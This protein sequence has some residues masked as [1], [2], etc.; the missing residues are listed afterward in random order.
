[1]TRYIL[2][3]SSYAG[4]VPGAVHYQGRVEGEHPGSCH[5]S[6]RFNAPESRGKWTCEQNHEMPEQVKW[7]V[8]AAWTEG[9]YERRAAK[10]FEGAGPQQ[11]A[12]EQDVKDAAIARFTGA[13]PCQWWE[14]AV[15]AGEPGD[16]L[17]FG[18]IPSGQHEPDPDGWG[19]VMVTI[20]AA[21]DS[22]DNEGH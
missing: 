6:T 8:E 17:Y 21:T 3:I 15:T 9:Q 11:F 7:S 18:Y 4:I 20:T 5:G 10:H 19:G 16:T 14:E 13:A 12:S 22:N 2:H 1:M